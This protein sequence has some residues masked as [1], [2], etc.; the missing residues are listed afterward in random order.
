M[1]CAGSLI[2]LRTSWGVFESDVQPSAM[3]ALCERMIE[4]LVRL[5]PQT[6]GR[7]A[8]TVRRATEALIECLGI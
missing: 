4:E 7:V 3:I 2:H 8:N 6:R 5:T 1:S